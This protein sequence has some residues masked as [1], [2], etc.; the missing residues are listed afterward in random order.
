MVVRVNRKKG[1]G[2]RS[3]KEG[4]RGG[5]ER[6]KD[7]L[8]SEELIVG[9]R[10]THTYYGYEALESSLEFDV[11]NASSRPTWARSVDHA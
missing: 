6:R 5:R 1:E 9:C 3:A 2:N 4:R 8:D 10:V 7:F 11:L